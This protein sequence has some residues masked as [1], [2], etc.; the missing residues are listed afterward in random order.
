MHLATSLLLALLPQ[1]LSDS[2]FPNVSR[3]FDNGPHSFSNVFA[4]F[5][6]NASACTAMVPGRNV[7]ECA[8]STI[9]KQLRILTFPL[10][11]TIKEWEWHYNEDLNTIYLSADNQPFEEK[12][13]SFD[14]AW[15]ALLAFWNRR[16][17][18]CW[19]YRD[20]RQMDHIMPTSGGMLSLFHANDD[21]QQPI[22][23]LSS[24][25]HYRGPTVCAPVGK[26]SMDRERRAR[27]INT[28]VRRSIYWGEGG[29]ELQNGHLYYQQVYSTD[30]FLQAVI[31]G[32]Q[33]ARLNTCPQH[34]RCEGRL[35]PESAY[36]PLT[37]DDF[38]IKIKFAL[39]TETGVCVVVP[40]S[41][42]SVEGAYLVM[43][44]I[45]YGGLRKAWETT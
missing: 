35:L 31:T 27:A 13:Q 32:W 12:S 30:P 19:H 26:Y 16:K 38:I 28:M 15:E 10:T 22:L 40:G 8:A 24:H 21:L 45:M 37:G 43:S 3:C 14:N 2:H 20:P 39:E 18:M 41:D 34:H 36:L 23:K 5:L 1:A 9:P 33:A 25:W 6:S 42:P 7:L 4:N 11:D 17:T 44:P 29:T